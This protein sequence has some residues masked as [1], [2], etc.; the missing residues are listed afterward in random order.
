MLDPHL[1]PPSGDYTEEQ[2]G[3]RGDEASVA[4]SFAEAPQEPHY[5]GAAYFVCTTARIHVQGQDLRIWGGRL[6]GPEEP[7]TGREHWDSRHGA[8]RPWEELDT[9][10][11]PRC[12]PVAPVSPTL[13]PTPGDF[14]WRAAPTARRPR[15]SQQ[16]GLLSSLGRMQM[17]QAASLKGSAGQ[18][19][20]VLRE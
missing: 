15:R 7:A 19:A 10:R 17:L 4:R 13:T 6:P 16:S 5:S 20:A 18:G 1:L 11:H 2:A 14:V 12:G 3:C 8:G 9:A